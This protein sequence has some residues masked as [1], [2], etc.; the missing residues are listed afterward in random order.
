MYA[1][2]T[3]P[4]AQTQMAAM[5]ATACQT[6]PETARLPTSACSNR[7]VSFSL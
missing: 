7:D 4:R 2:I 3:M 1:M 6:I 5:Y